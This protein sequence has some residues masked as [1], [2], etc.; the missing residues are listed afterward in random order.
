MAASK[1]NRT[2]RVAGLV[3]GRHECPECGGK[4]ELYMLV[5]KTDGVQRGM[6]G[7]CEQ[8]HDHRKRELIWR[9]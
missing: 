4:A 2:A 5:G 3:R 6:R 9:G 1:T 8:G 7:R